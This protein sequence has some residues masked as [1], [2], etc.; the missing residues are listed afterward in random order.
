MRTPIRTTSRA[1][2]W[3]ARL[4]SLAVLA[5]L[6]SLMYAQG[7]DPLQLTA[8]E[9][10]LA[11]FFP[12]GVIFGLILGWRREFMGG[13]IVI[14]SVLGFYA[15]HFLLTGRFPRGWAFAVM[16]ISGALFLISAGVNRVRPKM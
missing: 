10:L 14:G 9:M 7:F 13:C 1:L 6:L 12:L 5:L 3:I 15:A 8:R 16:A 2:R 4:A 11:V